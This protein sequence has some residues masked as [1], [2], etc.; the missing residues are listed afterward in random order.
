VHTNRANTITIVTD[1]SRVLG[2]GDIGP[3]AALPVMEG[4]ALLFKHLGGVDTVPLC[5]ATHDPD[6]LVRTVTLLE[7][8][9]GGVNLE[10]IAQP[11][12]F[13]VLDAL[14]AR[15]GIPVWHDDQQG[16]ATAL[17]A[18]LINAAKVVGKRLGGMPSP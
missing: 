6:E 2:L 8:T 18:G 9:F 10:D 11:K 5:L 4:K 17:L 13:R 15:A 1:G 16:T 3:T 7:P 12:C 14:R